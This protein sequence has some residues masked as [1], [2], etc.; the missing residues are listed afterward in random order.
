MPGGYRRSHALMATE[1]RIPPPPSRPPDCATA[2]RGLTSPSSLG[3]LWAP[4]PVAGG[5]AGP[6]PPRP[7]PPGA[8]FFGCVSPLR[9]PRA[10]FHPYLER[11][12]AIVLFAHL[13]G[14][15]HVTW[16][17]RLRRGGRPVQNL[18]ASWLRWRS[19][20]KLL[21]NSSIVHD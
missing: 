6:P 14:P 18:A 16:S 13:S 7:T 9:A 1:K 5:F 2:D 4:T 3:P 20:C 21:A 8:R 11:R 19:G 12:F 17:A 10:C 15:A